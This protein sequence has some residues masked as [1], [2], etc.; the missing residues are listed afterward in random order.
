MAS[1]ARAAN[2]L[3]PGMARADDHLPPWARA[4]TIDDGE[5]FLGA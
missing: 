5:R 2:I 3:Q 1:C 4:T